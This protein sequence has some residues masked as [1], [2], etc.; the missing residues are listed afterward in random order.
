MPPTSSSTT[1]LSPS[2]RTTTTEQPTTFATTTK[3]S[4]SYGHGTK[5]WGN[6]QGAGGGYSRPTTAPTGR[7]PD[8]SHGPHGEYGDNKPEEPCTTDIG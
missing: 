7:G 1:A 6:P 5:T 4:R 3:P 2:D 8:G